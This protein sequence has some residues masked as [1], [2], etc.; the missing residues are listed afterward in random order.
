MPA[1][2]ASCGEWKS[3]LVPS[4]SIVAGVAADHAAEHLHERRLA[5]AVLAHQRAHLAGA[6]EVAVA[7]RAHG[8]VGL[9]RVAQLD[10]GD[11]WSST[12]SASCRVAGRCSSPSDPTEPD[13]NRA[14]RG[15]S[16]AQSRAQRID[17]DGR[18]AVP[19][20]LDK[21]TKI[22]C[23]SAE[24][25]P[26]ARTETIRR[27]PRCSPRRAGAR[28]PTRCAARRRDRR[29]ARGALRRL[30]DDRAPRP[31]RARAARRRAPHARRRGAADHVRARGLVRPPHDVETEAK[32]AARRGRPSRCSRRARRSSSTPRRRAYFVARR[33]SR[34]GMPPPCSPTRCR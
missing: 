5:G 1:S 32:T 27:S 18:G 31:R 15:L 20:N 17:F 13:Q 23:L 26:I 16:R 4:T 29:R 33:W 9:A 25:I 11:D 34:R 21:P 2:R 14:I 3:D 8:A 30:A 7:Q 19:L 22:G 24:E 6:G 12:D 28:S 10:E